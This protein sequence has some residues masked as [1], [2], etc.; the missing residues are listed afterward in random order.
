MR[1]ISWIATF[2]II[3]LGVVF[4]AL[5]SNSVLVNYIINKRELPLAIVILV[6]FSFGIIFSILILGPKII[7]L[8]AR[9]KWLAKK[10]KKN[11]GQITHTEVTK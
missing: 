1:I 9:N 6:S 3:I 4:S 5:N 8:S 11:E 7:S 10:L 2:L